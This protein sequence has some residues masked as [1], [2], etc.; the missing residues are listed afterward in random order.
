MKRRK[1]KQRK[2]LKKRI[3]AQRT[4]QTHRPQRAQRTRKGLIIIIIEFNE[5]E[6]REYEAIDA[7]YKKLIEKHGAILASLR[8]DPE[9][10]THIFFEGLDPVKN[11][12][13]WI[14][15][16]NKRNEVYKEW[17]ESGSDEWKAKHTEWTSLY[18]HLD[19]EHIE[20]NRKA[21]MRH[22]N[23]LGNDPVSILN[24][25]M[26]QIEK[27]IILIHE[28]YNNP[29]VIAFGHGLWKMDAT[30]V[31]NTIIDILHIH[32]DALSDHQDL[33][34]QLNAFIID[35]I[36]KSPHI[37][38]E[39][40][41]GTGKQVNK[42][43]RKQ[44]KKEPLA[45]VDTITSKRVKNTLRP[46]ISNLT[47]KG[48]STMFTGKTGKEQVCVINEKY[49]DELTIS[50]DGRI[51]FKNDWLK[52]IDFEEVLRP[53]TSND[54]DLPLA[55]A[56]YSVFYQSII[57][58]KSYLINNTLY[59]KASTL[60]TYMKTNIWANGGNEPFFAKLQ[61][62]KDVYVRIGESQLSKFIT[63][64]KIDAVTGDLEFDVSTLAYILNRV[65]EENTITVKKPYKAEYIQ[66][67]PTHSFLIHSNINRKNLNAY[68]LVT[69]IEALLVQ[70]G[71]TS[72]GAHI[73]FKRLIE[74]VPTLYDVIEDEATTRQHKNMYLE[75]AFKK[76][77]E[78]IKKSTDLYLY[79]IDLSIPEIIP[80]QSALDGVLEITHRGINK[81]YC[82]KF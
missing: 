56:I 8:S 68:F 78:L 21:E 33:T 69:Q 71:P 4:Q 50:D 18:S 79:Y 17:V 10:N 40:V 24:D 75:R 2:P 14:Q 23:A 57:D 81:E 80:T 37:A 44:T 60:A 41:E 67:N 36:E 15:S 9:P 32:F 29:Y 19:D 51:A 49:L 38:K 72:G 59:I 63:L 42:R 25:A 66:E 74:R 73:K 53:V 70:A 16:I 82:P 26:N 6:K 34:D 20:L 48:Y 13:K 1:T 27:L 65:R 28:E 61:K 35:T 46:Y 77:Y 3:T 52:A 45:A 39:G 55:Q 5:Q 30:T 54:I 43:T 64:T 47:A 58:E 7:K 31:H 12:D 76:M 11:P 22:F 62:F